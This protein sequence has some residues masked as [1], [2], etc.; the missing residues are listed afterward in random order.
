MRALRDLYVRKDAGEISAK[1]KHLHKYLQNMFPN[2]TSRITLRGK[3]SIKESSSHDTSGSRLGF[4]MLHPIAGAIYTDVLCQEVI[5]VAVVYSL[6][7]V[8]VTPEV[9]YFEIYFRKKR[10]HNHRRL[11]PQK[12]KN[13]YY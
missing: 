1:D 9:G 5:L 2:G 12:E 13:I 11:G 8:E 3:K 7:D 6:F 10:Y 4:S